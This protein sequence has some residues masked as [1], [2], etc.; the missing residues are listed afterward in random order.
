MKY[1]VRAPRLRRRVC[2]DLG[3]EACQMSFYRNCVEAA[4]SPLIVDGS[5]R[6][7][8]CMMVECNSAKVM[9]SLVKVVER[10]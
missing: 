8:G 2:G 5:A 9:E 1:A 7:W 10:Y 4:P 6:G 3:S